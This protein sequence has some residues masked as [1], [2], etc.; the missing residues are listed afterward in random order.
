M[1]LNLLHENVLPEWAERTQEGWGKI[2][3]T[4]NTIL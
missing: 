2:L 3:Q 1:E 4:L